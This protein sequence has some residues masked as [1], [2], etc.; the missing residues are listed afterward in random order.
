M[1]SRVED[2][3]IHSK[4]SAESRIDGFK[5]GGICKLGLEEGAG[6]WGL[7]DVSGKKN[8]LSEQVTTNLRWNDKKWI[9]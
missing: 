6:I 2:R 8:S 5:G 1:K 9:M 3:K 7:S 4:G